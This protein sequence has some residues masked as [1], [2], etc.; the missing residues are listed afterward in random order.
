MKS[1]GENVSYLQ[2]MWKIIQTLTM[3][4][5]YKV[6]IIEELNDHSTMTSN[7][8]IGSLQAHEQC[9]DERS[10]IKAKEALKSQVSLRRE[11]MSLK[12]ILNQVRKVRI[13]K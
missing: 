2:V 4:F 13:E 7:E 11:K 12:I 8:L 10:Q 3:Q 5:E 6:T 9:L 1:N